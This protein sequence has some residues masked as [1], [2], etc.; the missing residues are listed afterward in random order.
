MQIKKRLID[1][2]QHQII[3]AKEICFE[4]TGDIQGRYFLVHFMRQLLDVLCELLKKLPAD[5]QRYS[6]RKHCSIGFLLLEVKLEET[7]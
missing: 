5:D 4:E 6:I 1:E 7:R 3:S 2:N